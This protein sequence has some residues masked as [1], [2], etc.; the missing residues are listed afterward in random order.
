MK[1]K[2]LDEGDKRGGSG[3]GGDDIDDMDLGIISL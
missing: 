1:L 3:G 2:I